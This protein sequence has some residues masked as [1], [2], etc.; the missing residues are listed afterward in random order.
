MCSFVEKREAKILVPRALRE[1]KNPMFFDIQT[2]GTEIR[3]Q[4]VLWGY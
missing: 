2:R 1:G 4:K 3:K